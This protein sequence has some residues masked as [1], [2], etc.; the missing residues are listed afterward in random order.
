ME[1]YDNEGKQKD[2]GFE[3][4]ASFRPVDKWNITANYAF[5]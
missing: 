1:S 5:C 4:E 3:V 2:N